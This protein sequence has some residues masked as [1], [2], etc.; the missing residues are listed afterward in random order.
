MEVVLMGKT[1]KHKTM[2][3]QLDIYISQSNWAN[4]KVMHQLKQK[5][6]ATIY[7]RL[8]EQSSGF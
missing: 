2:V 3:S 7:T 1:T 4:S 6:P 5:S 8:H